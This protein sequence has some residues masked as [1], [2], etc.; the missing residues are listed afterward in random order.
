[1][2]PLESKCSTFTAPVTLVTWNVNSLKVRVPR[3]LE[4]LAE[5]TP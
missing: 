4:F 5:H 2:S 1:M 3:V